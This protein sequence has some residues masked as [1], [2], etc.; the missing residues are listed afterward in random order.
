MKLFHLNQP[1][2]EKE[3]YMK[4]ALDLAAL[5]RERVSP[6]PMVGCVIV[7]NDL[8]IGEGF[9][10]LYG[11]AHAEV[12]AIN[13]VKGKNILSESDIYLTLEPCSHF[14]KT[15]PCVDLLINYKVR[16]VFI[17]VLDPNP[18]V[19]GKGLEKLKKSGIE[20]EIGLLKS[21]GL[22]LNK[23]FFKAISQKL[24]FVVIKWAETA[25]GF[26]ANEDGSP[27]KITSSV[28]NLLVHKWRSEEAAILVGSNTIL[29]DN[30]Q[31]DARLWPGGKSPIR[32]LIDRD[33]KLKPEFKVFED[34]QKTI[35]LNSIVEKME[36]NIHFVKI[37]KENNFLQEAL[38]QLINLGVNS[39]FVE[40]G[41]TLIRQFF[42]DGLY[43]EIRIFKSKVI[44]KK[45][46]DAP[47]VPSGIA[48]HSHEKIME[49]FLT[50]YK[51]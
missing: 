36:G 3:L 11:E 23:R 18:L 24:P 17:S 42:K 51:R 7:H 25:D 20:V 12:N 40:G 6:N 50:I 5:G 28:S 44:L 48:M 30:P 41:P 34:G 14:G 46:I 13:S 22:E 47:N 45:G 2:S 4:R 19:A 1:M 8:I 16:K 39:V 15:P 43:D 33:L 38:K 37:E 35:V 10:E 29:N 32:V 27:F 21:E 26:V 31:L 49:D 9:H